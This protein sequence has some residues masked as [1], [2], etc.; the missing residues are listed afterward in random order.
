[1]TSVARVA[2]SCKTRRN[3]VMSDDA[4]TLEIDAFIADSVVVAENK[5]FAQGA[6]WDSIF[7]SKFPLRQPRIGIAVF[8][9]IP[10]SA[11]NKMHTFS[12]K[13]D[14]QDGNSVPLGDAP[15]GQGIPNG[16]IREL[17]GQFNVGRPP[18]LSPGDSQI[19]PIA[20]NLDGLE[21]SGPNSYSVIITVDEKEM[22]RLPV[23]VR[24]AQ[25]PVIGGP[26]SLPRLP[27]A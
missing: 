11:T 6:G 14:D 26:S 20:V 12:I 3:L 17:R 13:M 19:V 2:P 5:L 8:L 24:S 21:F 9:R 27:G 15:Q 10:W 18:L 1:M 16:K 25:T 7:T 4:D 23:R 22:R